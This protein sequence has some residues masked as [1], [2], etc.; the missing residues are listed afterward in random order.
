MYPDIGDFIY[1]LKPGPLGSGS[2]FL[3]APKA[4]RWGFAMG[5]RPL[6]PVTFFVACHY[7]LSCQI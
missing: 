3:I 4:L 2:Q 1:T 5:K 7:N 6:C